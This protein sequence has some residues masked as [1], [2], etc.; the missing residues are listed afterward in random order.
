[1]NFIKQ[2]TILLGCLAVGEGVV[3]L[4]GIKLPSSIIGLFL[5]FLILRMKI[6]KVSDVDGVSGFLIKNMGVFFV[7]PCIALLNYIGVIKLNIVPLLVVSLGST[8]L[9]IITTGL[10]HQFLRKKK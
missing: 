8:L 9:V 2:A 6:I 4:T 1:M 7:P 10:T 3:Y 5:L